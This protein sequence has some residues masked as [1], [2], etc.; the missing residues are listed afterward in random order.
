MVAFI[1]AEK[2]KMRSFEDWVSHVHPEAVRR[3]PTQFDPTELRGILAAIQKESFF[4]ILAK[5][6]KA[7]LRELEI[8]VEDYDNL[9]H[10]FNH[11][12]QIQEPTERY[13]DVDQRKEEK[14]ENRKERI[15]AKKSGRIYYHIPD[16][17]EMDFLIDRRNEEFLE[18]KSKLSLFDDLD[19]RC[20]DKDQRRA[21][22]ID[23]KAN[24]VIASAGS[25]K[26]LTICAK[27]FYLLRECH[28][29]AD[30]ILLL[31]YSKKSAEDLKRRIQAV[32]PE[33]Q[34]ST[35]HKLG[36]DII[37]SASGRKETVEEQFD[38]IV[39]RYFK[40]EVFQDPEAVRD[41]LNYLS[42]YSEARQKMD[43]ENEGAFFA[44][45]KTN[46][47]QTMKDQV[48]WSNNIKTLNRENV[49]S[50][51][52][53]QIAN[54]YF[55]NG[56]DYIYEKP[57]PYAVT[58]ETHRQYLPDFTLKEGK[59]FHEHYGINHEG[60][61]PQFGSQS[62]KYLDWMKWKRQIHQS[63]NTMCIETFSY[64]AQENTLFAH[65]EEKLAAVGITP[66]PQTQQERQALLSQIFHGKAERAILSVVR[67]FL[68]LYKST[69]PDEGAFAVLNQRRESDSYFQERKNAFLRIVQRAYRYYRLTLEQTQKIDFDD[70]IFRAI[71]VLPQV[72]G[73]R[74]RYILVDEFQDISQSRASLLKA[75]VAHGGAK[76]YAVGDDWQSIYR[77]AGSD[78]GIF[79]GFPQYF[80]K[81]ATATISQTHRAPQELL[82]IVSPFIMKNG[83]QIRKEPFSTHHVP[84][85]LRVLTY[86]KGGKATAF[87][88]LLRQ[89]Q[90]QKETSVLV[91]GRNREDLLSLLRDIP[92][93]RMTRDAQGR[94]RFIC[95]GFESLDVTLSTV[96]SAKG[97][98]DDN[99]I[100][101]SME[102]A[103]D[104]FP[105]QME[106]DPLLSLLLSKDGSF[107]FS[108]ERRLFYVALTRARNV[109]YLLVPRENPSPFFLEIKSNVRFLEGVDFFL[110]EEKKTEWISCPE[111]QGGHLVYHRGWV[112][113]EAYY[114]CSNYPYCGYRTRA[115]VAVRRNL[116]CPCCGNFLTVRHSRH[117]SFYGCLSFPSCRYTQP[118]FSKDQ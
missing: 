84:D 17:A 91:L 82:D 23:E 115:I 110:E 112:G 42:Y 66:R 78:L 15:R 100:L 19:G 44:F 54:W 47:Y 69:Y 102:D 98:E 67:T 92:D 4:P 41:L 105:N 12:K 55:L 58:D 22:L 57:Y 39:E 16:E 32:S 36:L 21:A 20:L 87:L 94:R 106:D 117:G 70:M 118:L 90:E 113:R 108:E 1:Q 2:E 99:V 28:V 56:I 53:L 65:L 25:G 103:K 59:V 71:Q 60:K 13:I 38:A 27:I 61:A 26:T 107:P 89:I 43:F 111:C 81:T 48:S 76:L 18:R 11:Q 9:L 88:R 64:E 49:K 101:V 79:V 34:A 37:E 97:L 31:S 77:F 14:E 33:I 96:H 7:I 35:F 114:R 6:T 86:S 62:Q 46:P 5:K 109:T 51:E 40:R 24:L 52:E 63:H 93:S 50:I 95:P 29:S 104:G 74:Y 73:F 75:L 30:Q 8:L 68:S 83:Q 80:G 116:R 85:P 3:N 72:S 10:Q 45:L